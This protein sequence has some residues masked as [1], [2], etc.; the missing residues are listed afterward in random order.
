MQLE[1]GSRQRF[2][3]SLEIM[4]TDFLTRALRSD[5]LLIFYSLMFS[6]NLIFDHV[7]HSFLFV[8]RKSSGL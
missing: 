5:V 3:A 6:N 1:V 2:S 8:S 4:P 7:L